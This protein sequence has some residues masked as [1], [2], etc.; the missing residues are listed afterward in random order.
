ME[1]LQ[2]TLQEDEDGDFCAQIDKFDM[3]AF[4]S[5]PSDALREL[6]TAMDMYDEYIVEESPTFQTT[7]TALRE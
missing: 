5:T 3:S 7:S 6:A 1:H 4:A 2:I